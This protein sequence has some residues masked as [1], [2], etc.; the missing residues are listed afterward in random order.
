MVV[1]GESCN[2]ASRIWVVVLYVTCLPYFRR[3]DR[4]TG[5][6]SWS[7]ATLELL[8]SVHLNSS[9]WRCHLAASEALAVAGKL[10]QALEQATVRA[11]STPDLEY[12]SYLRGVPAL[13]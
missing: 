11:L 10:E 13:S 7:E 12:S 9:C 5:V 1:H 6:G 2:H 3:R 4:L 8:R